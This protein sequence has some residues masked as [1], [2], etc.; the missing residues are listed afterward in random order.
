MGSGVDVYDCSNQTEDDNLADRHCP[1]R[2]REILRLLHLG[3]ETR[4]CDLSNE[5]VA[6][7]QE[8]VHTADESSAC[9]W[10]DQNNGIAGEQSALTTSWAI[11]SFDVVLALDTSEDGRKEHGNECEE[12]GQSG[13]LGKSVEGPGERAEPGKDS[14]DCGEADSADGATAHGV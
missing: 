7:I 1:K 10:D 4:D 5:C 14:P 11:E 2:L 3:D 13:K 12:C 8:G 9:S 6:D